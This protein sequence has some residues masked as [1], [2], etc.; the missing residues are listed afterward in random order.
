[1]TTSSVQARIVDASLALGG[2]EVLHGL[3]QEVSLVP[4][5][6]GV[7][8]FLAVHPT[9]VS[10][11]L[12][13]QPNR[14]AVRGVS[15]AMS[16]NLGCPTGV[17]RFFACHRKSPFWMEPGVGTDWTRLPG[18]TQFVLFQRE[19]GNCLLIAPL[20]DASFRY[21][22]EGSATGLLINGESNDT[23][24][25]G[26]GPG[27][28]AF[29]ALGQE[30]Y[31][32]IAHAARAVAAHFGLPLRHEKPLPDFI[33][34]F[35][36]C[37]WDAFYQEVTPEGISQGLA[38]LAEA[39]VPPRF[40]IIDDGWLSVASGLKGEQRLTALEPNHK[41]QGSLADT[42]RLAKDQHGVRR[43]LAWH[44]MTGS[45]SGLD[46]TRLPGYEVRQV[47]KSFGPGVLQ[48]NPTLNHG[49]WGNRVGLPSRKAIPRFYQDYHAM[50]AAQGIDGV[51]VDGQAMMEGC[52]SGSG[53]RVALIRDF[54][55]ALEES[56]ARHFEGRLINCMSHHTETWYLSPRS[57]LTRFSDDFYPLKADR[58]GPHLWINAAIGLWFGEF[59]H[60]DWD[61]FHSRHPLGAFHAAGRAVSGSPLYVS[62]KPGH[63]D[64]D[65]L[66]KLV[67]PDGT[68]ARARGVGRLCPDTLFQDPIQEPCLLKIFNHNRHGAV[69]GA[70]QVHA[71][72]PPLSGQVSAADIPDLA[73]SEHVLYAHTT[74]RLQRGGC[75]DLSLPAMGWEI[76]TLAP[77]ERG[78][79]VVGLAHLMNSGA[80]LQ[81]LQ[82][83]GSTCAIALRDGGRL[84]AWSA[85]R[86]L[87]VRAHGR[88]L[89]YTFETDTGRLS[90]EVPAGGAISCEIEISP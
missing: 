31:A 76:V 84:V 69:V 2:T 7:G 8:A 52:A 27:V 28:A 37:T 56:V 60:G 88:E 32:L 43:V 74:G 41:F 14:P 58:H 47:A 40:L 35:G 73:A 57:N 19:D 12:D 46:E 68:V 18:E 26:P 4:D 51:K 3:S 49:W 25:R 48:N 86:P 59:Q 72:G 70:F 34:D 29:L 42:V 81:S 1:M 6:A 20:M 78:L 5:P 87:A 62:D 77:V 65:L 23:E 39:G 90:I 17:R 75:L 38:S 33:D 11:A 83:S 53:G 15:S 82:W 79:A 9:L 66:H 16:W 24:T 54:R 44:A 21:A 50:L 85:A 80:A 22:L 64:A 36:W 67:F 71:D 10:Q 30:P 13:R 63:H 61:M 55:E 45:W 89:S